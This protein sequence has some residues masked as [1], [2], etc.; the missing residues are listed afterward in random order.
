MDFFFKLEII[1]SLYIL[2]NKLNGYLQWKY[3]Y[4]LLQ[5]IFVI[6]LYFFV[7]CQVKDALLR[8]HRHQHQR[9]KEASSSNMARLPIIRSLAEIG[10]NHSSSKSKFLFRPCAPHANGKK[11]NRCL[12]FTPHADCRLQQLTKNVERRQ[13]RS[14]H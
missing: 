2:I 6:K 10:R 3:Y 4:Y 11:L 5:Y 9:R 13:K 12:E 7:C 1:L 14:C 8:K